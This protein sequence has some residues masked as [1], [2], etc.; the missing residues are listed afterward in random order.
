MT[1]SSSAT[2]AKAANGS[3]KKSGKKRKAQKE[4]VKVVNSYYERNKCK[5]VRHTTSK[6]IRIVEPSA[7]LFH[8]VVPLEQQAS[9]R[10]MCDFIKPGS[11]CVTDG[12]HL[13]YAPNLGKHSFDARLKQSAQ[14]LVDEQIAPKQKNCADSKVQSATD[15]PKPR[16]PKT[17]YSCNYPKDQMKFVGYYIVDGDVACIMDQS[18]LSAWKDHDVDCTK[19]RVGP[20]FF[21]RSESVHLFRQVKDGDEYSW[22]PLNIRLS[23]E[24]DDGTEAPMNAEGELDYAEE[25]LYKFVSHDNPEFEK[26][27]DS[28]RRRVPYC[29]HLWQEIGLYHNNVWSV[30]QLK[31]YFSD[32]AYD[33]ADYL[34]CDE[35]ETYETSA[36]DALYLRTVL[37]EYGK[38]EHSVLYDAEYA[39]RAADRHIRDYLEVL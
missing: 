10:F 8:I 27:R 37:K 33:Y 35:D 31:Q 14:R 4:V 16:H 34:D 19:S 2:N 38:K 18:A 3:G 22:F 7:S 5:R 29:G 9:A 36:E 28:N 24:A 11:A 32:C 21:A 15:V 20:N 12:V 26:L 17:F 30:A 1:K 23:T 13:Y 39:R 25:R 6:T